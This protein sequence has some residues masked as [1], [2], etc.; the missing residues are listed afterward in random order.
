MCHAECVT[1]TWG[2]CA[3]VLSWLC[4]GPAG[5]ELRNGEEHDERTGPDGWQY[6]KRDDW[7]RGRP[8]PPR[9]HYH[10]ACSDR[11][12]EDGW[13]LTDAEGVDVVCRRLAE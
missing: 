3:I 7:Q 5:P 12:A 4:V 8:T 13:P 11:Q 6:E 1:S 2:L 9:G 10:K